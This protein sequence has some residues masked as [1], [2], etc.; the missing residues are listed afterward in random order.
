MRL[1]DFN[2][3]GKFSKK[4][5]P[6]VLIALGKIIDSP[7]PSEDECMDIFNLL[8]TNGDE[9][10]DRGEMRVLLVMFFKLII[11]SD[12]KIWVSKEWTVETPV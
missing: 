11:K 5:F 7:I 2:G 10:I 4:E 6:K 12:I 3:D 8:D 1:Y 9:V